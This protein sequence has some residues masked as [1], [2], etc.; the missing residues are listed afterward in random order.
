MR[1]VL[2]LEQ[3]CYK[4]L[5]LL[6]HPDKNPEEKAAVAF[7]RMNDAWDVLCDPLHRAECVVPSAECRVPSVIRCIVASA[8]PHTT[9]TTYASSPLITHTRPDMSLGTR[10]L[11][12][13]TSPASVARD[14]QVYS[15]SQH[16][17]IHVGQ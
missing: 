1:R 17:D 4:R 9:P 13:D 14:R 6:L 8:L 5:A 3:A 16:L 11:S 15:K 2:P 12:L 7:K 10:V